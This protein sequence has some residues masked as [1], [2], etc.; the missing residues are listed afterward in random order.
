ML[1]VAS[2]KASEESE[3]MAAAVVERVKPVEIE[4]QNSE[5]ATKS[6]DQNH[7]LGPQTPSH[8]RVGQRLLTDKQAGV[9]VCRAAFDA[10]RRGVRSGPN[11]K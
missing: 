10:T 6:D 4:T 3:R 2:P 5:R 1:S 9:L 7:H 8:L 11:A